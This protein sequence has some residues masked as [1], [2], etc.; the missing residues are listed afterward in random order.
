MNKKGIKEPYSDFACQI[1]INAVLLFQL[2]PDTIENWL[3]SLAIYF[4]TNNKPY[5]KM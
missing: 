5:S 2:N 4:I 1:W 3:Y